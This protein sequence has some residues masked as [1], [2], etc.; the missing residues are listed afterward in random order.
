MVSLTTAGATGCTTDG[1]CL[2]GE[3]AVLGVTVKGTLFT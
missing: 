3:A 1:G 2:W